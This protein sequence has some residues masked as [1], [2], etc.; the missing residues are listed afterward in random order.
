MRWE[1]SIRLAY[2]MQTTSWAVSRV[3]IL[4]NYIPPRL[5]RFDNDNS[6]R[7]EI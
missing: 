6:T 2:G 1:Y 3:M 5:L 4:C 7:I